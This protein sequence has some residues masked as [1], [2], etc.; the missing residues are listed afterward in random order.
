MIFQELFI[1]KHREGHPFD[2]PI[3]YNGEKIYHHHKIDVPSTFSGYVELIST[4][5]EWRQGVDVRTEGELHS[6]FGMDYKRFLHLWEDCF[7]QVEE[8]KPSRIQFEGKTK[9]GKLI[10][11]NM[12][13]HL[14][15]PCDGLVMGAAMKIEEI[16]PNH[17]RYYCNDGHPDEDFTDIIFDLVLNI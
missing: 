17:Y 5:S 9:D 1:K 7:P 13:E 15:C 10:I 11:Y 3:E 8:G 2:E 14:P 6:D 12:W 4:H 16:A